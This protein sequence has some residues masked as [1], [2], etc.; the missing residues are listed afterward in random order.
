MILAAL[1]CPVF[2]SCYDDSKLWEE[3]GSLKDRVTTLEQKLNE[4]LAVF[5]YILSPDA[6]LSDVKWDAANGVWKF[7]LADG[8]VH[9][10]VQPS[11]EQYQSFITT[12]EVDGAKYWA[13]YVNGVATPITDENDKMFPISVTPQVKTDEDGYTYLSLDGEN[14][15]QTSANETTSQRTVASRTSAPSVSKNNFTPR[16]RSPYSVIIFSVRSKYA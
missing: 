11:A 2:T 13:T 15:L 10:F 3:M 14:W 8:T 9:E 6:K 16:A 7:T 5:Q 12:V 4:E 1:A